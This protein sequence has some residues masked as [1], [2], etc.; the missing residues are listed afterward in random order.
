LLVV[1]DRS[2]AKFSQRLIYPR[3]LRVAGQNV[4]VVVHFLDAILAAIE[5]VGRAERPT[6]LD[7]STEWIVTE[8]CG[9]DT[10][11]YNLRQAVFEVLGEGFAGGVG[12]GIAVCVE[13]CR[14]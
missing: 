9:S 2:S 5:V 11:I 7:S 10:G 1:T 13:C 4:A 14:S 12:E 6:L 3:T 8:T